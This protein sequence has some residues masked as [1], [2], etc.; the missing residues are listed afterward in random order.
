MCRMCMYRMW[1]QTIINQKSYVVS[2]VSQAKDTRSQAKRHKVAVPIQSSVNYQNMT[3]ILESV[4]TLAKFKELLQSNPGKLFIKF[5]A[6]WCVP[7]QKIKEH[8]DTWFDILSEDPTVQCVILDVDDNFE[9]YAY[10]KNKKMVTG[11]PCVLYY[12]QGNEHYVCDD[13]VKGAS[14]DEMDTFFR[15]YVLE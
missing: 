11:I 13:T 9:V 3:T 8:I 1:V 2:H 6:S 5:T 7:C 12:E 10:L 15:K 4:P 14:A